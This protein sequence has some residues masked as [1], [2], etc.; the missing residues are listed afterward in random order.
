MFEIFF[1]ID[2]KLRSFWRF[3]AFLF[4]FFILSFPIQ[5]LTTDLIKEAISN[6]L[7]FIMVPHTISTIVAV[8]LGWLYGRIFEGVHFQALGL[9]FDKQG[10]RDFVLGI[11]IGF[12]SISFAV[13]ISILLGEMRFQQNL[14][15]NQS[16]FAFSATQNFLI[17]LIASASEE[18]LFRGYMLQTFLRSRLILVGLVLTSFLFA[19]AHNLNP[20]VSYL[21]WVNTFVAGI[22]LGVAYLKTEKLWLSIAMHLSWNWFQGVLFGINVSGLREFSENSLLQVTENGEDFISG[23]DY[24]IEGGIACTISVLISTVLILFFYP[25]TQINCLTQAQRQ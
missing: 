23:G 14:S 3:A 8:G 15:L 1:D 5:V 11:V 24:G 20:H 2:G 6:N 21:S 25:K 13:L 17:F 22:W 18:A 12:F 7:I 4:S 10:L 16:T 19:S 9:W